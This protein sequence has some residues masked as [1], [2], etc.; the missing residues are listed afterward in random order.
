MNL[1]KEK[2]R[3]H[4]FVAAMPNLSREKRARVFGKPEKRAERETGHQHAYG[5]RPG[6][7]CYQYHRWPL[8]AKTVDFF[9]P[10]G[11]LLISTL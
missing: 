8:S 5:H 6:H 10:D 7:K 4:N 1:E 2:R 9:S 11:R 3:N